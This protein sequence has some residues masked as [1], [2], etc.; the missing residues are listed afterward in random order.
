[1]T[2]FE[3]S[4]TVSTVLRR[5]TTAGS[6]RSKCSSMRCVLSISWDPRWTEMDTR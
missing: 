6:C 2:L 3:R 5:A 1:M 4:V